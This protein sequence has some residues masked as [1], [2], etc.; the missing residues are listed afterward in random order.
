LKVGLHSHMTHP[1]RVEEA[2]AAMTL[3]SAV[4]GMECIELESDTR[5]CIS[6]SPNTQNAVGMDVWEEIVEGQLSTS[7]DAGVGAFA[8][9]YHGCQ[10]TICT[11]EEKYPIEIE[12][13]LSIFAR[14]LGIE[15]EDTYKKYSLWKDPT[16]VL[17]DMAPC[18]E[19]TGVK[20]ERAK[21]L[22]DLTF[23]A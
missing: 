12:H 4:P 5:L 1:K 21:K 20:P 16:R 11:Y 10:R 14:G 8:T 17:A 3:L 2:R 7:V 19:A 15:H 23:P 22:V 9:M 18:M 6:C 13:Y